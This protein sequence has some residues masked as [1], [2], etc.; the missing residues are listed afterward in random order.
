MAIIFHNVLIFT[1]KAENCVAYGWRGLRTGP[2]G[3]V[4]L[5]LVAQLF[6]FTPGMRCL[7]HTTLWK[8]S[9]LPLTGL[10]GQMH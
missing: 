8:T 1:Q 9:L 3:H 4:T 6:T 5:V 7:G 2:P 10:V